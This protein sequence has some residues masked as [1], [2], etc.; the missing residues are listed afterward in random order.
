M[1]RKLA[2]L[3]AILMILPSF[4]EI[5]YALSFKDEE[6][7]KRQEN[8]IDQKFSLREENFGQ[9]LQA[10]KLD[11]GKNLG[12]DRSATRNASA[13]DDEFT[14]IVEEAQGNDTIKRS[15]KAGNFTIVFPAMSLKTSK[16]SD[17]TYQISL[18]NASIVK[19]I[20]DKNIDEVA[21][22]DSIMSVEIRDRTTNLNVGTVKVVKENGKIVVKYIFDKNAAE[23]TYNTGRLSLDLTNDESYTL[24]PG[25]SGEVRVDFY[26]FNLSD[27]TY[28]VDKK[29]AT[30]KVSKKMVISLEQ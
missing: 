22:N 26:G 28:T 10:R 4:S 2:F 17:K 7:S 14:A 12:E 29:S 15:N 9:S 21:A 1:K 23:V 3:L 13:G 30:V 8:F 16:D 18:A 27:P 11:E 25:S 20:N 19:S 5:G 24:L 6:T